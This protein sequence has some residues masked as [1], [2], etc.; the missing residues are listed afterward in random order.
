MRALR[1]FCMAVEH[2]SFRLAAEELYLTASAV[3]HQIRQLED[4]IGSQL[5]AR[6]ARNLNVTDAG[7]A[8]YDDLK[9]V[10][11][12][13]DVTIDRNSRHTD[14]VVLKLS[15]QPFF[16]NELL[17]PRLSEF[18][19]E[20]P[21]I[22]ITVDTIE[23]EAAT[24]DKTAD[25]SIRLFSSPPTG[26]DSD[27]LFALRL[28]PVGSPDFYDSVKVVAGRII[29]DFPLIVHDSRPKAWQQW[30]RS[31][32]IRLPP[33]PKIIRLNSMTS[34]ARAAE[35]GLGAALMP[36]QL[37][38]AWMESGALTQLFDHELE[39]REAYYLI[40]PDK[41]DNAKHSST[42]RDWVLQE[43]AFGS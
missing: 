34:I 19:A 26:L 41:P 38:C 31:S 40:S 17:V 29:S 27:H 6:S 25:V 23:G 42:F 16:A 10:L 2:G 35:Q 28:A 1:A 18:V 15:V 20:N 33:N 4:T 14:G 12:D 39:S 5:F 36:A 30:Q 7:R 37:C 24:H 21:D 22:S 43:F 3:S 9:P 11:D 13:L 8:F 32:G